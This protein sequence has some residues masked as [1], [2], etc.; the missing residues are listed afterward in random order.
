MKKVAAYVSQ[1]LESSPPKIDARH[2]PASSS[3]SSSSSKPKSEVANQHKNHKSNSKSVGSAVSAGSSTTTTSNTHPPPHHHHPHHHH[4]HHKDEAHH[5]HSKNDERTPASS[6]S[7]H[8]QYPSPIDENQIVL[9]CNGQILPRPITLGVVKKWIWAKPG[10]VI[11]HY[12]RNELGSP[13]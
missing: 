9:S 13:T 12:R 3:P 11:I 7:R 5:S 8:P 1:K 2:P 4:R 10:D 6:P